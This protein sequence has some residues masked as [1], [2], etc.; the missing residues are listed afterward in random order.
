MGKRLELLEVHH[1]GPIARQADDPLALERH[2]RAHS[3]RQTPAHGCDARVV[4]E[5]RTLLDVQGL[6]ACHAGGA[7]A[8]HDLR[9]LRQPP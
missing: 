2:C 8:T 3:G 5:T 9:A 4:I 7:V 6:E 1:D